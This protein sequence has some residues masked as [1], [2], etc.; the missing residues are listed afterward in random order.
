MEHGTTESTA[1]KGLHQVIKIDEAQIEDRL[2]TAL[3]IAACLL[4][5]RSSRRAGPTAWAGPA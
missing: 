5:C 1:N 4:R 3:A 2:D